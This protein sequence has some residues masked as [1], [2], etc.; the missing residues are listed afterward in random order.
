[1]Q[2]SAD[3]ELQE[4]MKYSQLSVL[5][6]RGTCQ[7][8]LQDCLSGIKQTLANRCSLIQQAGVAQFADV[9]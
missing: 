9:S 4:K 1:M 5:S 2:G 3:S 6:T 8:T 7:R